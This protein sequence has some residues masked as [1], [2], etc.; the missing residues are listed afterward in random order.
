MLGV[1]GN[2]LILI[3]AFGGIGNIN[4]VHLNFKEIIIYCLKDLVTV[5][6]TT[7]FNSIKYGCDR[8][9]HDTFC[10]VDVCGVPVL[11][12]RLRINHISV[13]G[14]DLK[15]SVIFLPIGN[16]LHFVKLQL[17]V[18]KIVVNCIH[19]NSLVVCSNSNVLRF[20]EEQTKSDVVKECIPFV[21]SEC[22]FCG[23]R[24]YICYA[25]HSNLNIF[26]CV[27]DH[28]LVIGI[29]CNRRS[30][31]FHHK[32]TCL[33]I[34]I[35]QCKGKGC[36]T[37]PHKLCIFCCDRISRLGLRGSHTQQATLFNNNLVKRRSVVITGRLITHI[38][39]SGRKGHIRSCYFC[40]FIIISGVFGCILHFGS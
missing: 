20:L 11:I 19:A 36:R 13:I 39:S 28:I 26:L 9:K 18:G 16:R 37:V 32:G 22:D 30:V 17:T 40:I 38:V 6:Y 12:N 33:G 3:I 27:R 23:R 35:F 21:C 29:Q 10:G 24:S 1:I 5:I 8:I 15:S 14:I 2:N 25:F 4:T 34:T 31:D 7:V